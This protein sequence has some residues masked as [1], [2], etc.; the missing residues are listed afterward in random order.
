MLWNIIRGPYESP[1]L[2]GNLWFPIVIVLI[3]SCFLLVAFIISRW[4]LTKPL[5][6]SLIFLHM[7][8]I[9]LTLLTNSIGG[10]KPILLLPNTPG[11]SDG[12]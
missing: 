5:G 11:W 2:Q 12:R 3:Y 6:C 7:T 1:A 4:R 9:A 10:K 8:F